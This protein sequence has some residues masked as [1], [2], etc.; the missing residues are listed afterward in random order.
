[1]VL[2]A[3][4]AR[5]GVLAPLCEL[6]AGAGMWDK[7]AE[8]L[9][10]LSYLVTAPEK[11]AEILFRM[12]EMLRLQL[13]DDERAS[14]AYLK[15]IDLDPQ[16]TPTMRRLIDYY[17][18]EADDVSL[19]EMAAELDA[20]GELLAPDTSHETLAKV[21]VS[22]ALAGE[23][24]DLGAGGGAPSL[25]RALGEGGAGAVAKVLA[26]ATARRPDAVPRIVRVARA[27]CRA[28]GPELA[29]VK[30]VLAARAEKDEVAA[31]LASLL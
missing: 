12:G 24:D 3:D 2:V 18:A 11:R 19:A 14:D 30:A 9:S 22:A 26:D 4:P 15:A 1:M 5:I 10:R 28:P 7:A 16:H 20:R 8:A 31:R 17:W 23:E 29:V 13:G 6:Y 25:A 27:L 21:A